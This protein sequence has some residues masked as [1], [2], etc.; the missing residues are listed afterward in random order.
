MLAGQAHALPTFLRPLDLSHCPLLQLLQFIPSSFHFQN[1]INPLPNKTQFHPGQ[2]LDVL[3]PG[4][5]KAGGFTLTSTPSQAQLSPTNKTPYLE[6]AVQKSE[7][8]P[9]KWLWQSPS[10]IL[11]SQLL[12]RVGGSFI[13]PPADIEESE[14]E[15]VIFVAGG[16]GIK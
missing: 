1:H 8:P 6:L 3:I 9:A 5:P 16:V 11:N 13:W 12:V 7:N 2:W 14:I 15:K 4:L 10:H